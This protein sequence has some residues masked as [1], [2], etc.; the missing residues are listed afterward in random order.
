LQQSYIFIKITVCIVPFLLSVGEGLI[1]ESCSSVKLL[2]ISNF[3]RLQKRQTIFAYKKT[4]T[5]E[6]CER[7]IKHL[8]KVIPVVLVKKRWEIIRSTDHM[9]IVIDRHL[10]F[11][12]SYH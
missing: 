6:K 1:I 10:N 11:D 4:L 5:P 12:R 2:I 9:Y 8:K 7:F 3:F